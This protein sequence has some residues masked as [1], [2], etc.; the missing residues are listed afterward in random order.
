MFSFP[1]FPPPSLQ[2]R[3]GAVA[4]EDKQQL[5]R[6]RPVFLI[7]LYLLLPPV[8][9]ALPR[10]LLVGTVADPPSV[11]LRRPP[12]R[13]HVNFQYLV[14]VIRMTVVARRGRGAGGECD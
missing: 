7:L 1:L 10:F 5:R 9:L 11:Q 4:Q 8:P 2:M 12:G 13:L 6:G 14:E 3:Q